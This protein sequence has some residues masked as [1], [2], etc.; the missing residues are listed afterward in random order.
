VLS[1]NIVC[2]TPGDNEISVRIDGQIIRQWR[3]SAVRGDFDDLHA[4]AHRLAA[5]L[6]REF[7]DAVVCRWCELRNGE[8]GIR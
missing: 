3:S 8:G 1:V 2:R 7:M 4:D 6:S 5:A